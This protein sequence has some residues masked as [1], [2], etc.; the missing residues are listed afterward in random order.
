M[1]NTVLTLIFDTYYKA[2]YRFVYFRVGHQADTEDVVASTF[3][4]AIKAY[5]KKPIPT[6]ELKPW[7]YRI[8][9]NTITDY[10]RRQQHRHT[11][12]IDTVDLPANVTDLGEALDQKER[13]QLID[14][15]LKQL[16]DRQ[17]ELMLLRYESELTNKEIAVA[18]GITEKAVASQLSKAI[19]AIQHLI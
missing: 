4:K 13:L 3:E 7:L 2:I 19:K 18:T 10:Y 14:M 9:L 6:D 12:D 16:P 1:S 5:Y 15:V 11:I 17:Q 8:A